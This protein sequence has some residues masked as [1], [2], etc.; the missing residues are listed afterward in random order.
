MILIQRPAVL[1]NITIPFIPS[2]IFSIIANL[3][4]KKF[5]RLAKKDGIDI[6]T[7]RKRSDLYSHK[8]GK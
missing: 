7:L 8:V 4:I 2:L 6:K 5:Y 3:K 1:I